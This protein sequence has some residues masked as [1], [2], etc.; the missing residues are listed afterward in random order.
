MSWKLI[1]YVGRWRVP[2]GNSKKLEEMFHTLIAH[3][4]SN[5]QRYP[6]LQSAVICSSSGSESSEEDWM[7]VEEYANREAYEAFYK[8]LD[9][10]KTFLEIHD[11]KYDFWHLI[12]KDS[13]KSELYT[14][15]AR[16]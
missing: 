2:A 9:E 6:Q 10:D 16:F 11:E 13:F 5:P 14:E 12:V 8:A 4:K 15:R 1:I 7:W 3:V